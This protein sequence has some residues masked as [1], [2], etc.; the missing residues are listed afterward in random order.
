[1][2]RMTIRQKLYAVFGALIAIFACVS[3]YSGYNLL[4]LPT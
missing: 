1:M 2:D 4:K 3:L